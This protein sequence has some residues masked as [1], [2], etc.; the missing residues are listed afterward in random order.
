MDASPKINVPPTLLSTLAVR[1]EKQPPNR[2][3]P[4]KAHPMREKW[5]TKFTLLILGLV[6]AVNAVLVTAM[7][8]MATAPYTPKGEL[9]V[10]KPMS[11]STDTKTE[12][13]TDNLL[14]KNKPIIETIEEK[15]ES[16]AT[17][18]FDDNDKADLLAHIKQDP[19]ARFP[20]DTLDLQGLKKRTLEQIIDSRR[21]TLHGDE[22]TASQ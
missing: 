16:T 11:L 3:S 5:D 22:L 13:K 17:Y 20:D 9:I 15:A 21:T 4:S 6:F 10:T 12:R 18:V 14:Q 8:H 19:P 1:D 2:P 7:N